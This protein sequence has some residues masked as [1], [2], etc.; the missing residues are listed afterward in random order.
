LTNRISPINPKAGL[1]TL[2][3][4]KFRNLLHKFERKRHL[5][6]CFGARIGAAEPKVAARLQRIE[7]AIQ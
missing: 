2:R 4:A 6:H 3:N 5:L 1:A 7:C